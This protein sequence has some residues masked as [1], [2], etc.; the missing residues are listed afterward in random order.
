[1]PLIPRPASV[2]LAERTLETIELG[3]VK[4]QAASGKPL[5]DWADLC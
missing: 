4:A 1:M 2:R 5:I 3:R